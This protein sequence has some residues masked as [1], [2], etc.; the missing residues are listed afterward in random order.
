MKFYIQRIDKQFLCGISIVGIIPV[1]VE[2]NHF[3]IDIMKP[4]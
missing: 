4:E 3:I 1:E 2:N